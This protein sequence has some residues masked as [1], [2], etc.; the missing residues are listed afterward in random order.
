MPESINAQN[1]IPTD[2]LKRRSSG[3]NLLLSSDNRTFSFNSERRRAASPLPIMN[4]RFQQQPQDRLTSPRPYPQLLSS[5]H[6]DQPAIHRPQPNRSLINRDMSSSGLSTESAGMYHSTNTIKQSGSSFNR[7]SVRSS[8]AVCFQ[9]FF[10]CCFDRLIIP[11]F[12]FAILSGLF[13]CL[14]ND[15]GS[16][17]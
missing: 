6:T 15:L 7:N 8:V 13:F 10:F 14:F 17:R 16:I 4:S 3:G 1:D 5:Q 9:F 12:C 11:W 2:M